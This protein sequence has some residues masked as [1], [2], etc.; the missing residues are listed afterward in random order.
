MWLPSVWSKRKAGK[1]M[2]SSAV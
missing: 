2:D 1:I